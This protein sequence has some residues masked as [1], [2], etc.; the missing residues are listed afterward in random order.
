MSIGG[1]AKQ[2][3]LMSIFHNKN[4]KETREKNETKRKI[5]IKNTIQYKKQKKEE[6]LTRFSNRFN[7]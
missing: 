2:N 5:I 1:G 3:F 7:G 6:F 4:E